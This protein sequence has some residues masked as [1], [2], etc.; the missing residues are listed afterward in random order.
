M[1]NQATL[2]C[3]ALYIFCRQQKDCLLGRPRVMLNKHV[4][5]HFILQGGTSVLVQLNLKACGPEE[6]LRNVRIQLH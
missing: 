6:S 5:M 1:L 3:N 2:A 4:Y